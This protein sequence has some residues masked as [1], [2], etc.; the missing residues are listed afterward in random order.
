M[1]V[2][3]RGVWVARRGRILNSVCR[4]DP[5]SHELADTVPVHGRP[6][7]LAVGE[8]A[9]WVS[10]SSGLSRIRAWREQNNR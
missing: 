6:S 1:A 8:G 3:A 9:V 5:E 7:T 2:D 10:T 4:V